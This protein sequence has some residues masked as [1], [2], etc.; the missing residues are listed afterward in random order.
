MRV[1]KFAP[2]LPADLSH[3]LHTI[4]KPFGIR[5]A[6]P[7]TMGS[8]TEPGSLPPA[9]NRPSDAHVFRPRFGGSYITLCAPLLSSVGLRM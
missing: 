5:N 1:L 7:R 6:L 9:G 8:V 2:L 3:P 4:V